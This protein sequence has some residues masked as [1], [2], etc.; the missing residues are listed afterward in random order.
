VSQGYQPSISSQDLEANGIFY[1]PLCPAGR[2]RW[3]LGCQT[4]GPYT[5]NMISNEYC[6]ACPKSN[7]FLWN[8]TAT[9]V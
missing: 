3:Y 2:V 7:D 1:G 4:C 5:Y 6:L 8:D 9:G